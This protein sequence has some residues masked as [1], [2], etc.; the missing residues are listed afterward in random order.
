MKFSGFLLLVFI[1]LFPLGSALAGDDIVP[2]KDFVPNINLTKKNKTLQKQP[3]IPFLEKFFSPN[4]TK[5]LTLLDDK[6]IYEK[7]QAN[8][9]DANFKY[10]FDLNLNDKKLELVPN[11][12]ISKTIEEKKQLFNEEGKVAETLQNSNE[13]ISSESNSIFV[14][15]DLSYALNNSIYLDSNL[16]FLQTDLEINQKDL[17]T[18]TETN[19]Y[20]FKGNAMAV[21]IGV[22]KKLT[23]SFSAGL[24]YSWKK[25][26]NETEEFGESEQ[27]KENKASDED[28]KA[29]NL[30]LRYDF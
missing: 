15:M 12:R 29:L 24:M 13:D 28:Q 19:A 14:G 27:D 23:D 16:S 3:E 21:S 5:R 9:Y 25:W 26:L 17:T 1:I 22:R 7:N 10:K 11:I 30:M 18:K 8:S 20:K 4:L 6:K 2:E